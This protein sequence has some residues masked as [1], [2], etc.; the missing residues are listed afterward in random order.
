MKLAIIGTRSFTDYAYMKARLAGLQIDHIVSGGAKGADALAERYAVENHIPITIHRPDY[1]QHGQAAPH[2]RNRQV[3]DECHAVA[4]FWHGHPGGTRNSVEYTEEKGKTVYLNLVPTL[5]HFTRKMILGEPLSKEKTK[6]LYFTLDSDSHSGVAL[7]QLKRRIIESNNVHLFKAFV[8]EHFAPYPYAAAMRGRE[9]VL[10]PVPSTTGRNRF[11]FELSRAL[12]NEFGG[13]IVPRNFVLPAHAT[14]AKNLGGI[15]RITNIRQYA[16]DPKADLSFYKGKNIVIVDDVVTTGAS[17][18]GLRQTLVQ[19]GLR[20]RAIATL[21]QSDLRLATERDFERIS[22]KAAPFHPDK[23]LSQEKKIADY[24]SKLEQCFD[25][26]LKNRLIWLERDITGNTP[27]K[28]RN[29]EALY[30]VLTG[31]IERITEHGRR[32][33]PVLLQQRPE[34]E[35]DPRAMA[36]ASN[37]PRASNGPTDPRAGGAGKNNDPGATTKKPRNVSEDAGQNHGQPSPTGTR[38]LL[39]SEKTSMLTDEIRQRHS[40]SL[41]NSLLEK[42][43]N[44]ITKHNVNPE[45]LL[46]SISR[47]IDISRQSG[48]T[49]RTH[50]NPAGI[51]AIYTQKSGHAQPGDI[52]IRQH[53]TAEKTQ[54]T[55]Y[56]TQEG[57]FEKYLGT[58]NSWP[59]MKSRVE[60][61]AKGLV[62]KKNLDDTLS[63]VT[64]RNQKLLN[65]G[66]SL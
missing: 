58:E 19:K 8:D 22:E 65:E 9:N 29:K 38:V 49:W 47:S 21:C 43:D 24:R 61:Y 2:I 13:T 54:Y 56:I 35:L 33:L 55:A 63:L 23:S 20:T 41:P 6:K 45:Q 26:S 53:Q 4:A 66:L 34:A 37:V 31:E 14:E 27:Q 48:A 1:E 28:N 44:L 16:I 46:S 11:S 57:P 18:D 12:Q 50:D 62:T 39:I 52:V 42:A 51:F 7:K 36:R 5:D 32:I 25:G 40:F 60:T 3:V 30:G 15:G 64:G 10:I 59:S 17:I